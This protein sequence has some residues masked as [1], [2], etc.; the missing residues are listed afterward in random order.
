M[1]SGP[2]NPQYN[3]TDFQEIINNTIIY[4]RTP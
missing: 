3:L 2:L 1:T 4:N